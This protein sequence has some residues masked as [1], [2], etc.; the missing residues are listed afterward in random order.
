MIRCELVPGEWHCLHIFYFP[1]ERYYRECFPGYRSCA[2][3]GR[4][5]PRDQH[6]RQRLLVSQKAV[7]GASGATR[8]VVNASRA[9]G[10]KCPPSG[11]LCARSQEVTCEV[12]LVSRRD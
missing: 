9:N 5:F 12:V 3:G 8:T 11:F 6:F 7:V 10:T 4:F 1:D 2:T